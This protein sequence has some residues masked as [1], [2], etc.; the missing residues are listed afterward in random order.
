MR[1]I[2]PSLPPSL[3]PSMHSSIHPS[4][5]EAEATALRL[6]LSD[7][8]SRV[9]SRSPGGL[10]P[11]PTLRHKRAGVTSAAAARGHVPGPAGA[12]V[13]LGL[14]MMMAAA[15]ASSSAPKRRQAATGP[16]TRQPVP[17]LPAR[18]G[19]PQVNVHEKQVSILH[20]GQALQLLKVVHHMCAHC[21]TLDHS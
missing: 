20:A 5:A 7:A 14:A 19:S 2:P 21:Q 11:L 15:S 4:Q 6:E 12:P 18:C 9:A 16:S 8:W 3:P 10:H 17:A 1:A 13:G